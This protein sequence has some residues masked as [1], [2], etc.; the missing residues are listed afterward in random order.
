MAEIIELFLYFKWAV[1][2]SVVAGS[3]CALAGTVLLVRRMV[4][5][6]IALPQAASAGITLVLLVAQQVK[7]AGLPAGETP[8]L[9]HE[10]THILAPLGSLS[11][12]LL[13]LVLLAWSERGA[14]FVEAQW[15]TV[16]IACA[17]LSILF[18]VNNPW[19]EV[20]MATMLSGN[21]MT[22]SP[23]Q[24]WTLVAV[25]VAVVACLSLFRKEFLLVAFDPEMSMSLRMNVHGW[26]IAMYLLVGTAVSVAVMI[27]GPMFVFGFMLLPAFAA[28]PWARSMFKFGVL[29]VVLA[30]V[31][32]FLGCFVSF[33][34]NWPLGASQVAVAGLVLLLSRAPLTVIRLA[35]SRA[36]EDSS[37]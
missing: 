17:A 15:G 14:L 5:L 23:T 11:T 35:R 26:N 6:G 8:A 3:L 32:A 22:V 7:I 37:A 33:W 28:R 10:A 16:Y 18:L 25:T 13:V 36:A 20:H 12:V 34:R 2:S 21:V 29:S 4:L 27:L 24:F 31:S 19:G 1:L 30:Q 9:S